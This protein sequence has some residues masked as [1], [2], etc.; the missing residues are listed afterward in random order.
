MA[1]QVQPANLNLSSLLDT[2][3]PSDSFPVSATRH[4][5]ESALVSGERHLPVLCHMVMHFTVALRLHLQSAP[6]E[7]PFGARYRYQESL[8]KSSRG[9]RMSAA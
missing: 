6:P 2:R 9:A 1:W 3:T 4:F 8:I 5:I 7:A